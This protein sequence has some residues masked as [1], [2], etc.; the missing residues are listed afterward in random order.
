[1]RGVECAPIAAVVTKPV[2][3]SGEKIINANITKPAGLNNQV[4][5]PTLISA[6]KPSFKEI[7]E[8]NTA[9]GMSSHRAGLP[10]IPMANIQPVTITTLT[11][12]TNT[13]KLIMTRRSC[14]TASET[15][16]LLDSLNAR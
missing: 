2:A 14:V 16:S 13:I 6:K 8:I 3:T 9:A 1:M 10:K 4:K 15:S 12:T 7:R 11:I 5:P